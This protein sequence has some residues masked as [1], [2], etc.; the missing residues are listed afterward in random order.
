M[1]VADLDDRKLWGRGKITPKEKMGESWGG[2]E[3]MCTSIK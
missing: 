3:E 2:Y 1:L